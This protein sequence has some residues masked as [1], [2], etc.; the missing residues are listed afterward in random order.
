MSDFMDCS[1]L[2]SSVPGISQAKTTGVG[3]HFLPFTEDLPNPGI[4]PESPALAGRFFTME[5]P[6]KIQ[7]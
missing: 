2:G 4:K 6:E 1:L 7:S 3:C 5:P